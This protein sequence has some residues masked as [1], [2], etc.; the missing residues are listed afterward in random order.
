MSSRT[1]FA[2]SLLAAVLAGTLGLTALARAQA[3]PGGSPAIGAPGPSK[4]PRAFSG[5][6]GRWAWIRETGEQSELYVGGPSQPGRLRAKGANWAEVAQDGADLWLLGRSGAGAVLLRLPRDGEAPPVEVARIADAAG[7]LLAQA[8][9][10]FWLEVSAPA[11]PGLAFVPPLGSRLYLRCRDADGRIRTLLDRPAV[12]GARPGAGDL[13]AL[14]GGQVYLRLR[15]ASGTELL[16]MPVQGGPSTR[17]AGESGTQ[18]ALL[19]NGR[20]VWTAP[21]EE[22]TVESGINCLRRQSAAGTPELIAEWLPANGSLVSVAEGLR[23]AAGDDLYRLP[24]RPGAPVFLRKIDGVRVV[25]DGHSLVRL[26]DGQPEL[27]PAGR[28]P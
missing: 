27:V 20:L 2:L 22:A 18:Q 14:S 10:V 12:E 28:Q 7:G 6:E 26:G 1:Y 5:A 25:S 13:V 3:P 23:Y 11:D 4:L 21:S 16:S 19:W 17:I 9:Q 24:E 8:G 15:S